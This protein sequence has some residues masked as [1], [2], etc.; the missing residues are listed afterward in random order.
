MASRRSQTLKNNFCCFQ[1]T[2]KSLFA[3]FTLFSGGNELKGLGFGG[4]KVH[5]LKPIYGSYK[6]HGVIVGFRGGVGGGWSPI[7]ERF[8]FRDLSSGQRRPTLEEAAKP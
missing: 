6:E 5:A 8:F 7:G 3:V 1:K 2:E 4:F